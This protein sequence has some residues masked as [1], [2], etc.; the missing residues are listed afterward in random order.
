MF[1]VR[2]ICIFWKLESMAVDWNQDRHTPNWNQKSK[3][4]LKFESLAKQWKHCRTITAK[5]PRVG[6]VYAALD[7]GFPG[8]KKYFIFHSLHFIL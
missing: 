2:N 3:D 4:R 1:D 7:P 5:M 6:A 8:A